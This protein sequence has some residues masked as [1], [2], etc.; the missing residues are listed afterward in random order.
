MV[1][2][3]LQFLRQRQQENG[4]FVREGWMSESNGTAERAEAIRRQSIA[5]LDEMV[6]KAREHGLAQLPPALELYREKLRENTYDVLVVGEAKRGKSG[7]VNAPIG[8]D[9]PPMAV[10][11]ATGRVFRIRQAEQKAYR[12]RFAGNSARE[13]TAEDLSR[14]GSRVDADAGLAPDLEGLVHWIAVAAPVRFLPTRVNVLDTLGLGAL[15]AG[16][17]HHASVRAGGG[18]GDL[19]AGERAAHDRRRPEVHG[20]G[21][22]RD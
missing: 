22:D 2:D 18:R 8:R 14:C 10:D 17:P 11:A 6:E 16:H 4:T 13:T 20:E 9:V 5:V 19:R 12:V 15:Y 21:N 7:F 3:A 1:A